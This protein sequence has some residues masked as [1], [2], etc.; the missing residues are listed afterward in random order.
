M[1]SL[2]T[3]LLAG[4]GGA[5]VAGCATA[6][7]PADRPV[8]QVAAPPPATLVQVA[9]AEAPPGSPN[10]DEPR[11]E[12]SEFGTA[13][14]PAAPATL[15]DL[16]A[17][18]LERNPRLAQVGWTVEAARGR[19][20]QAGLYPNPTVSITGDELG[21][22]TGPGGIWTA[23]QVSQE[24]VTGGKLEL[25]RSAALKEV[26]QA[27]LN[28]VAERSRV[29]TEVRQAF[30]EAAILQARAEVLAELVKLS[31]QSVRNAEKLLKAKEVARLD[32]VQ[33]EADRERYRAELEATERSLPAA[34]RRLAASVGVSD[35]PVTRLVV[36]SDMLPPDYDLDRVR[37]YVVSIHPELRAAQIAVERAQLLVRRAQAE[38]TP[39][40]TVSAGY[41]RQGQ[42]KSND[43]TV[44]V[45]LPVPV[46]NGNQGNILAAS[47]ELSQAVAAVGRTENDLVNR[48]AT[49]FGMYAAA[50]RRAERYKTDVLP[51]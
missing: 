4:V 30:F 37:A 8:A 51:K 18:T 38:P 7:R 42:N 40:V 49:S 43:W 20:L 27:T 39:N 36:D 32:V 50:R 34:Y 21:D 23:P 33:L 15:P 28:V 47:A 26:D 35:L 48:L 19:A 41:V 9:H 24:I 25:S 17:L 16:V 5:L 12:P 3:T 29:L 13:A 11:A 10:A 2:R 45:S 6:P 46:W 1:P 14:T 22:R 44:G 31:D